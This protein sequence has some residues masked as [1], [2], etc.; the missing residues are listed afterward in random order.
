MIKHLFK[1]LLSTSI[2]FIV[3]F[4]A[5]SP[6]KALSNTVQNISTN[7]NFF[8]TNPIVMTLDYEVKESTSL[9]DPITDPNFN[10]MRNKEIGRTLAIPLVVGTLVIAIAAPLVTWWYFSK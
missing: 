1:I 8:D 7:T 6:S 9:S 2:C 4:T 3:L 5:I 10:V